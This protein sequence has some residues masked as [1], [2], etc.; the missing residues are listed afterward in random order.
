[1]ANLNDVIERLKA[2]G[3]LNRNSGTNS[4]KVIINEIDLTNVTLQRIANSM[5]SILS[6]M[7]ENSMVASAVIEKSDDESDPNE[8]IQE[9]S[10][11]IDDERD[12]NELIDVVKNIRDLMETSDDRRL[13]E[14]AEDPSSTKEPKTAKEVRK[15]SDMFKGFFKI[16]GLGLGA[17]ILFGSAAG[18]AL[19]GLGAALGNP[20]LMA[21][22]GMATLIDLF[23]QGNLL[24]DLQ[25]LASGDKTLGE[26]LE[27]QFKGM[28]DR[29]ADQM[30]AIYSALPQPFQDAIDTLLHGAYVFYD[31]IA[32]VAQF[33]GIDVNRRRNEALAEDFSAIFGRRITRTEDRLT[34][35]E[36]SQLLNAFGMT[37]TDE[38][39]NSINEEL[40]RL[41]RGQIP[42]RTQIKLMNTIGDYLEANPRM[43]DRDRSLLNGEN[44]ASYLRFLATGSVDV[45]DYSDINNQ[46]IAYDDNN[47]LFM[48]PIALSGVVDPRVPASMLRYIEDESGNII[49]SGGTVV[50]ASSNTTVSGDTYVVSGGGQFTAEDFVTMYNR[51]RIPWFVPD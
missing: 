39:G 22:G 4:N 1:M 31:T 49:G 25:A 13:R 36:A 26:I 12:E 35:T 32:S 18:P 45:P 33:M 47:N 21:V 14:N 50:D 5:Q 3:D 44:Y 10:A 29:I 19:L 7:V 51:N 34:G 48:G 2:E 17:N 9:R 30:V 8:V 42:E 6:T 23:L 40:S 28:A 38:D 15:M 24:S 11:K 43:M 46:T 37:L 27:D 41:G 20:M 16:A